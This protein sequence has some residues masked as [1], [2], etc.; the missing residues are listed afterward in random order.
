MKETYPSDITHSCSPGTCM[1]HSR[2][3]PMKARMGAK[4]LLVAFAVLLLSVQLG[5]CGSDNSSTEGRPFDPS[6][7]V[8]LTEFYPDSGVYQT[9]VILR[10]TN[11]GTD[12]SA[13]RVYFNADKIQSQNP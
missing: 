7:P 5:S 1:C 6:Q 13:I 10:G 3:C 4:Q 12:P 9:K 11:F 2:S 8:K